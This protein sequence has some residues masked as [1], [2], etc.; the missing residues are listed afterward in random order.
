MLIDYF[1]IK[2]QQLDV[3][4]LYERNGKYSFGPSGINGRAVLA[5]LLGILPCLPGFLFAATNS[6]AMYISDNYGMLGTFFADL[7]QYAWF[8]SL[9]IAATVHLLLNKGQELD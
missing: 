6:D 2:R 8:V 3:D 4:D 9:G 5:L 7:Y 1:F